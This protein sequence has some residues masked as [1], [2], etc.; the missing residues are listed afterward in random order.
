MV[1]VLIPHGSIGFVV[2]NDVGAHPCGRPGLNDND[3]KSQNNELPTNQYDLLTMNFNARAGTRPAP[4]GGTNGYKL[5]IKV[6]LNQS[7]QTHQTA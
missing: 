2:L 4:T 1:Q 3:Q 5:V 6:R 7:P